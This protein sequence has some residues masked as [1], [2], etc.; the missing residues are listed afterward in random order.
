MRTA[1][2]ISLLC[3]LLQVLYIGGLLLLLRVR[4]RRQRELS[5]ALMRQTEEAA[6][7]A[8]AA[9]QRSR[10][11]HHQSGSND[12]N[13]ALH[14]NSASY[15]A[16]YYKHFLPASYNSRPTSVA[17]G[18]PSS[19]LAGS[20][21]TTNPLYF[22]MVSSPM[23]GVGA[24]TI[25][26]NNTLRTPLLHQDT[27]RLTLPESMLTPAAA[28][29]AALH[30]DQ[31]AAFRNNDAAD[32]HHHPHHTSGGMVPSAIVEEDGGT[33]GDVDEVIPASHSRSGRTH[34]LQS[35][36]THAAENGDDGYDGPSSRRESDAFDDGTAAGGINNHSVHVSLAD[37]TDVDFSLKPTNVRMGH[38]ENDGHGEDGMQL[39]PTA[40][41][42]KHRQHPV[43]VGERGQNGVV[44][45]HSNDVGV[46]VGVGVRS[47]PTPPTHQQPLLT[48]HEHS[49]SPFSMPPHSASQANG[50]ALMRDGE[51]VVRSSKSATTPNGSNVDSNNL[52][53]PDRLHPSSRH[54]LH[55]KSMTLR[56]SGSNG[57]V[58][59]QSSSNNNKDNGS[60]ADPSSAST[61]KH[62]RHR[63]SR[64]WHPS[65]LAVT[66]PN[67]TTSRNAA[68][69]VTSPT[70]SAVDPTASP[71]RSKVKFA[72]SPRDQRS[73]V[74][75]DRARTPCAPT[76]NGSSTL[77]AITA[78]LP[79]SPLPDEDETPTSPPS[80]STSNAAQV[81]PVPEPEPAA[82]TPQSAAPK[83]QGDQ[84]STSTNSNPTLTPNASANVSPTS[85]L[86][87]PLKSSLSKKEVASSSSVTPHHHPPSS[88]SSSYHDTP[89]YSSSILVLPI[90]MRFLI[91]QC[92]HSMLWVI[93][94]VLL[95]G[96]GS[97]VVDWSVTAHGADYAPV[98]VYSAVMAI[99]LTLHTA[100]MDGL[101]L[102]L[103][104]KTVGV[105]T[106]RFCG[107]FAAIWGVLNGVAVVVTIQVAMPSRL[108]SLPHL[109]YYHPFF[110]R[111][112]TALSLTVWLVF[113]P[114]SWFKP[115]GRARI[116][117]RGLKPRSQYD[118]D[119]EDYDARL[120]AR[121]QY[122]RSPYSM[123]S[124]ASDGR[125][126]PLKEP[127][128]S[129]Y[130]DGGTHPRNTWFYLAVFNLLFYTILLVAYALDFLEVGSWGHDGSWCAS[131]MT[132]IGIGFLIQ[133]PLVY[134]CL[135]RDSKHWTREWLE[136]L[137]EM[138]EKAQREEETRRKKEAMKN[139]AKIT[140]TAARG[141][142]GSDSNPL[143]AASSSSSLAV[144]P[145][146]LS[147]HGS[148]N[149][150][151]HFFIDP[152]VL[153]YGRL[154]GSG[155]FSSVYAATLWGSLEVAV[156]VLHVRAVS[157]E[158]VEQFLHEVGIILQLRHPNIIRPLGVVFSPPHMLLVME[159]A[160]KQSLLHLIK[161]QKV[162]FTEFQAVSVGLA[163]ADALRYIH[164]QDIL[165][166][167]L[168]SANILFD[169]TGRPKVA[170]FGLSEERA[171]I[172]LTRVF[173]GT[174]A[175]MSPECLRSETVCKGSD[176][177]SFSII[178]WEML[179]NQLA[180]KRGLGQKKGGGINARTL[181]EMV[182]YRRA[183]PPI[184]ERRLDAE[185]ERQ[186][187][188]VL[189]GK[190][191][192]SHQ[193]RT[194]QS[195]H[196]ALHA[197]TGVRIHPD[198]F[199]S[200][201]PGARSGSSP[202]IRPNPPRPGI[203]PMLVQ[204]LRECW[205]DDYTRRPSFSMIVSRLSAFREMV[206]R[207]AARR[208]AQ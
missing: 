88:S 155:G 121:R 87:S 33:P 119:M 56:V 123:S 97:D 58:Q 32:R 82:A 162:H 186:W 14:V 136:T 117:N 153:E 84:K 160:R 74:R 28:V 66:I 8:S 46:G 114:S 113:A 191:H 207:S 145:S 170:D 138:K 80:I 1:S 174:L 185:E 60:T 85:T 18:S 52:V 65:S 20:G 177:Y 142:S 161:Y 72:D 51:G 16:G 61:T 45:E 137:V 193:S 35:I 41:T 62:S 53:R 68:D 91:V 172:D 77:Y 148:F 3:S 43:D 64:T 178:L 151:D 30:E 25:T 171:K 70:S 21:P 69:S 184:T 108:E 111:A 92:I 199:A 71:V 203:H 159:R 206:K 168:K 198:A 156:K 15:T 73:I 130:H 124:A 204:L 44:L 122:K 115:H 163:I 31:D 189:G 112:C 93:L 2:I 140:A 133:T 192:Q 135:Q 57:A 158:L 197:T 169:A 55:P 59:C 101:L 154:L 166:R 147:P 165:H 29:Y 94:M 38:E 102:F 190:Y 201:D 86:K 50:Y 49:H 139:A 208:G 100:V 164:E 129:E 146:V 141:A 99:L 150:L 67:G 149:S 5:R 116:S 195:I 39:L 104:T 120:E 176:V 188:A 9:A 128:P 7:M 83:E 143:S 81:H 37:E 167:D 11:Q 63:G 157:K 79:L 90:Y 132:W 200:P 75:G 40:R 105:A 34:H 194:A 47:D 152:S 126:P 42:S 48:Q 125:F 96:V 27:V 10:D 180:W 54:I 182:A 17:N 173:C 131:V 78:P 19:G 127:D 118:Q 98:A 26:P 110:V 22:D 202:P 187:A 107:A 4:G 76:A 175:Y 144:S 196:A 205:R 134:W 95:V 13:D 24:T 89:A 12:P 179:H 36:L 23:N 6:A 181:V 183:R 106:I 103:S 109:P